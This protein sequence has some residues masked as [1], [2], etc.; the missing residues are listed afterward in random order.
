MDYICLCCRIF[1]KVCKDGIAVLP[2]LPVLLQRASNPRLR[3]LKPMNL[4]KTLSVLLRNQIYFTNSNRSSFKDYRKC[5]MP[6][7]DS[8]TIGF[9]V[10]WVELTLL[11]V[12]MSAH[13]IN[14][15]Y[16]EISC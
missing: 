9:N 3:D 14:L 5:I 16:I 12:W 13:L 6:I 2:C 4:Q 1:V 8:D 11:K 7:T 10:L 15:Y